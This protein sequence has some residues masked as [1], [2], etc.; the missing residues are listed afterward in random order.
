MVSRSW[1][2]SDFCAIIIAFIWQN[3]IVIKKNLLHSRVL[4]G[5]AFSLCIPS[6]RWGS[7]LIS[8]HF[9]AGYHEPPSKET[10]AGRSCWLSS[11]QYL[12]WKDDEGQDFLRRQIKSYP[13][14]WRGPQCHLLLPKPLWKIPYPTNAD[15]IL[16]QEDWR[17]QVHC[18]LFMSLFFL[19]LQLLIF[20]IVL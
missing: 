4:P 13:V 20:S 5:S 9:I 18:G 2:R 19:L 3:T 16:R 8:S 6:I 10:K 7:R 1:L 15:G 14:H 17:R 12:L 11:S